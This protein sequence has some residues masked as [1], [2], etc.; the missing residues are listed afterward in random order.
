MGGSK[1]TREE[2]LTGSQGREDS[3]FYW[4]VEVELVRSSQVPD[5]LGTLRQKVGCEL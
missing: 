2:A 1:E 3:D 5:V 4:M